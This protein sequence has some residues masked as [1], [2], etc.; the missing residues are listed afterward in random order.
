[1]RL[2]RGV[3]KLS[4]LALLLGGTGF[5]A[6]PGEVTPEGDD[7]QDQQQPGEELADRPRGRVAYPERFGAPSDALRDIV[8]AAFEE[9]LRKTC[10]FWLRLHSVLS[11]LPAQLI[12]EVLG[13]GAS[14]A[15]EP[16]P[17]R[18]PEAVAGEVVPVFEER[19]D[20][21]P[22]LSGLVRTRPDDPADDPLDEVDPVREENAEDQAEEHGL[23]YPSV[24]LLA[25]LPHGRI[26]LEPPP[27]DPVGAQHDEDQPEAVLQRHD[28]PRGDDEVRRRSKTNELTQEAPNGLDRAADEA[29]EQ[30]GENKA[31]EAGDDEGDHPGIRS[32]FEVVLHG[33]SSE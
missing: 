14:R 18:L 29:P 23:T 32:I 10:T 3:K 19:D 5:A 31:D 6:D 20:G 24:H 2:R 17:E 30:A 4:L 15:V 33:G 12:T 8:D 21:A 11:E 22:G 13:G 16:E 28:V 9:S 1:M 27:H 7:Q 25:E 26:R